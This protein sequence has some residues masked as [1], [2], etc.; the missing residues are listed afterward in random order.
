ML[1][2]ELQTVNVSSKAQECC[3]VCLAAFFYF[4]SNGH[5]VPLSAIE[6]S[7]GRRL[8]GSTP[9]FKEERDILIVSAYNGNKVR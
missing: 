1:R 3:H 8:A 4:F 6:G 9:L 7:V 2:F 5:F